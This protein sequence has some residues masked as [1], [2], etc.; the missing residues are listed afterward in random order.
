MSYVGILGA[1]SVLQRQML[2]SSSLP[3]LEGKSDCIKSCF[4][5]RHLH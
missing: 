2:V 5:T 3:V 1:A 4:A